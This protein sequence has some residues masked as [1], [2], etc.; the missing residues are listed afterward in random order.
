MRR[1]VVHG[2]TRIPEAAT[3]NEVAVRAHERGD[4][5]SVAVR[6]TAT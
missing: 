3:E 4:K 5:K 2:P 6:G 1:E